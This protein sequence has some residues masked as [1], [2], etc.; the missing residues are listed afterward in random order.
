MKEPIDGY[1]RMCLRPDKVRNINLYTNGSEGTNL[2]HSCEMKVGEFIRFNGR[3][4]VVKKI[5][6][7]RKEKSDVQQT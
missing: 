7:F 3:E 6:K 5:A 2:C 4:A 1:C